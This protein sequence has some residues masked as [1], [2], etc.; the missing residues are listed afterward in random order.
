[1][2]KLQVFLLA[3]CILNSCTPSK[4]QTPK[5]VLASLLAKNAKHTSI[6][7]HVKFRMKWFNGKDTTP[8]QADCKLIKDKKDTLFR[9]YVWFNTKHYNCIKYFD[10]DS[11][12]NFDDSLKTKTS[13]KKTEYWHITGNSTSFVI[14][15][16][17]LDTS[18]IHNALIDTTI[19]G[20]LSKDKI[21]N[22][23][24]WKVTIKYKDDKELSN[25]WRCLWIHTND[26]TIR[27]IIRH[28]TY[29]E[30]D[31]YQEW[32]IDS[33]QYDK[34]TPQSLKELMKSRFSTYAL[35]PYIPPN[36]ESMKTLANGIK[37][38]AFSGTDFATRKKLS[39]A[40]YKGKIVL[41][42]FW[43]MDCPWCI[44]AM[45]LVEK[46]RDSFGNKGLVVLGVNSFDTSET[47]KQKLPKFI[48][49]NKNTYPTVLTSRSTDK[50]YNLYGYPTFYLINRNGKIA[51]SQRGYRSNMDSI[52]VSEINKLK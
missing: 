18:I 42:D 35:K 52:F 4:K 51:Y 27:K 6:S 1:M 20:S 30:N 17:F 21:G 31:E 26:S 24:F 39:L 29:Q 48:R 2:K 36:P 7:Y 11:I 32:D 49:I 10:L 23:E 47:Q 19:I 13:Y 45:P 28:C 33:I 22:D 44:T 14:N 38:P 8:I 41:L 25:N 15:T 46:I 37:A 9:G 16:F 5:S 40:D 50:A 34:E 43:Y 12:Y 3:A